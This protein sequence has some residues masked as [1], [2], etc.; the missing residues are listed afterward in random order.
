M[1][2]MCQMFSNALVT[3]VAAHIQLQII[4]LDGTH[5][6]EYLRPHLQTYVRKLQGPLV[7]QMCLPISPKNKLGSDCFD[8]VRRVVIDMGPHEVPLGPMFL[9]SGFGGV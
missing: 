5:V 7:F 2:T 9:F 8:D 1:Q 6:G 4:G 3:Q